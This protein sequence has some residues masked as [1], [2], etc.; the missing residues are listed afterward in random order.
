MQAVAFQTYCPGLVPT[1]RS[2][3]PGAFSERRFTALNGAVTRI[4]FGNRLSNSTLTLTFENISDNQAAQIFEHYYAVMRGDYRAEFSTQ[5][6]A[7]GAEPNLASWF[8]EVPS[9]LNWKY[10]DP[11][12]VISIRPGLSTVN[13]EFIGELEGG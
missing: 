8:L 9:G 13:C 12:Q 5:N 4:R 3:T 7:A 2:Y 1:S 11:P 6:V 10:K